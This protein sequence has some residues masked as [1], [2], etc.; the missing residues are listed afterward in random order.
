MRLR[1][2]LLVAVSTGA[3]M[4]AAVLGIHAGIA[5]SSRGMT[6]TVAEAR[7]ATAA[8][9]LGALVHEDGKPSDMLEDRLKVAAE[10]YHAGKV[11]RII[12]SGDHGTVEYDEPR[13]M[14]TTLMALGVPKDDIFGDHAGFDTRASMLRA[15]KVFGVDSA[16]VVTQGFHLPRALYLAKSAGLQ[17][18]GVSADLRPYGGH[19]QRGAI[20]EYPARTNAFVE[21]ATGRDVLL[22][23]PVPIDGDAAASWEPE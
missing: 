10:L 9:V 6:T 1:T 19:E 12:V 21:L 22:G 20:R 7:P 18:Q 4:V 8:I 15:R 3:A 23:P 16:V 14:R 5:W 13:A 17:A 11:R 2:P